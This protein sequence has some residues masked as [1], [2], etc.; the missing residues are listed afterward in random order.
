MKPPSW[1]KGHPKRKPNEDYHHS[2]WEARDYRG[3]YERTFRN[4]VGLV[5]PIDKQ[6]HSYLHVI[7]PPPPKFTRNEM[8]DCI[9]FVKESKEHDGDNR[10]YGLEAVMRY[11]VFL[12]MDNPPVGERMHDIRYNLAQQIG[13]MDHEHTAEHV[14][15]LN[16]NVIHL[17]RGEQAA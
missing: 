7:V 2:F 10:F 1:H 5:L 13:I 9:D 8:A 14:I 12:E 17:D 6:V 16:A 15:D 4:H 11:T 3:A